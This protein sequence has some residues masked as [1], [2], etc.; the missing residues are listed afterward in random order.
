MTGNPPVCLAIV[1][2]CVWRGQNAYSGWQALCFRH[3]PPF[4][5]LTL[6][7]REPLRF[8]TFILL[9]SGATCPN[10][11]VQAAQSCAGQTSA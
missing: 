8:V 3:T 2:Q 5:H 4:H 1:F 11:H 9:A 10:S 7:P 6:L